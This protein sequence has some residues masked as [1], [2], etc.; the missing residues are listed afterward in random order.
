MARVSVQKKRAE[1]E[2]F[3]RA[4]HE[5]WQLN[6][7]NQREYWELHGLPFKRFGIWRA[8]FKDERTVAQA[9]LLGRSGDGLRQVS[10][11]I[12]HKEIEPVSSGYV[13]SAESLPDGR[14][15]LRMA[16]KNR[17]VAEARSR[18]KR[19]AASQESIN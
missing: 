1:L 19:F 17:L 9:N 16:D 6:D 12:S 11:H 7:L 2:S 4:H 5:S 10:G 15:N 18:M 8:L 13:P 14:R 3:W